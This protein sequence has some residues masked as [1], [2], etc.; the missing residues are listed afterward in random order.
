MLEGTGVSVIEGSVSALRLNERRAEID[1]DGRTSSE[2]FDEIVIACD[3][4]L[5]CR[6]AA[7]KIGRSMDTVK[8]MRRRRA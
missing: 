3:P 8:K 6:E 7:L 2:A 1:H 4:G 5:T